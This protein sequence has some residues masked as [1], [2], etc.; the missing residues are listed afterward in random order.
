LVGRGKDISKQTYAIEHDKRN[1]TDER[2]GMEWRT[3]NGKWI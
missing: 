1:V 3:E 2:N